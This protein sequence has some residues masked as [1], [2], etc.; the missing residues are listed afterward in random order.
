M[1]P[2]PDQWI[3]K[4]LDE[5]S[6]RA[7]FFLHMVGAKCMADLEKVLDDSPRPASTIPTED[8]FHSVK[9]LV[10]ISTYLAVLEQSPEKPFEWLNKW[11]LQVLTQ[12]DEMIPEPPVRSLTDLLGA[13]DADE[14]VRYATEKICLTL[15]LRRLENQ[16]LLWDMIDDEKEFRNEILV[17]ALSESLTK[18][19]D[20]AALFP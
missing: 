16:D 9:L 14:I 3:P 10:C 17:M 13:L 20:H 18:L 19:E 4:T 15:K 12:L 11:L 1:L 5:E 7:Y 2:V 6:K 8:V